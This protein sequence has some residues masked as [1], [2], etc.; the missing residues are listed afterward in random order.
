MIST[1]EILNNLG[2]EALTPM[3]QQMGEAAQAAPGLVL[4][5]PTGTGKTLA[6]LLPMCSLVDAESAALQAVVVVP[7]RELAL[8]SHEALKAMRLPLRALCLYGGRPTMQEHRQLRELKPHIVFAT[9]GRLCDHMDKGNL[10]PQTVRVLT[11]DEFDK[12]LELGFREE[13]GRI[14]A[15]FQAVRHGW[16]TSA[17]DTADVNDYL[18]Q[19]AAFKSTGSVRRLDFLHEAEAVQ[20]R[21]QTWQVLSAERDKLHALGLLLSDL[22][23]EQTIVFVAHRESAERVGR[24]LRDEGFAAETYHGGMEQAVRE[25]ALYKFRAGCA[26]V[27]VSTDLAARG[28]DVPEVSAVVHYHLPLKADDFTHRS[29]RTARWQAEGR[30]F[31]LTGPDEA[32]PDF[33]PPAAVYPLQSARVK[34]ARP[35]YTM[36]YIGRGKKDKLSKGDVLGFLC[37]KGGLRAADLGRIDVADHCAYAAVRCDKVRD[38]LRKVASEKIKG[39][40]TIVQQ[41]H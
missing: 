28:L 17:T 33:V 14:A 36:I 9:P 31:L 39:M 35:Q 3:Q 20:Q 37:K 30:I 24:Y 8:Q 38:M 32:W 2:I 13:M 7:S 10:L 6:Y 29:G 18:R 22:C 23:N 16:L 12:C 41:A 1:P 27:L 21:M 26:R 34:A 15:A 25:K 40:K 5:S 11:I 19:F 4:L